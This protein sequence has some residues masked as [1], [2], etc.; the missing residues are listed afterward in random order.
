MGGYL[1]LSS[2][3][4]IVVGDNMW[5]QA[6]KLL[7]TRKTMLMDLLKPFVGAFLSALILKETVSLMLFLGMV[8]TATGVLLVGL[9]RSEE[10]Q[11]ISGEDG[12]EGRVPDVSI[13]NVVGDSRAVSSPSIGAEKKFACKCFASGI[14]SVHVGYMCALFNVLLDVGGTIIAKQFGQAYS[15]FEINY[16]RFGFAGYSMGLFVGMNR[17]MSAIILKSQ[18]RP[19]F[20][21]PTLGRRGWVLISVGAVFVTFL[22]P[23]LF[24][25]SIFEIDLAVAMTLSCLG[26]IYS[27]PITY[28]FKGEEVTMQ[29]IVGSL[30]AFIGVIP[31][32][33][34]LGD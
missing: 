3:I 6:L 20:I 10:T 2:L 26:P 9:E 18:P 15:T 14:S 13:E 11:A 24:F 27:I 17:A 1:L 32:Y 19:S 8:F 23:A 5:L 12:L 25:Y 29:S 28:W 31:L 33:F 16:I 21:W 30:F 34:S 4:G 7:G 22:C